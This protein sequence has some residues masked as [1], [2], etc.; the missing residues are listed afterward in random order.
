MVSISIMTDGSIFL[1]V[2]VS[3][4][5]YSN[6]I[7]RTA[8][9]SSTGDCLMTCTTALDCH[10]TIY[11]PG[12][13]CLIGNFFNTSKAVTYATGSTAFVLRSKNYEE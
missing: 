2:N 1:P 10:Y 8:P 6:W 12:V 5:T 9:G 11:Q 3:V 4:N 7:F 13:G